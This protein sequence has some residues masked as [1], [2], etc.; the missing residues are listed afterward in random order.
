MWKILDVFIFRNIVNINILKKKERK[1]M[2]AILRRI[3][4]FP[5]KFRSKKEMTKM[6]NISSY[7]PATRL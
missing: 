7:K 1:N 4:E 3:S 6:K 5:R 2:S